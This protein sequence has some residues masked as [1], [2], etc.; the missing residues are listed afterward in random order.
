L[1]FQINSG[2]LITDINDH[3]PVLQFEVINLHVGL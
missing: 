1:Q 3:L 2:L